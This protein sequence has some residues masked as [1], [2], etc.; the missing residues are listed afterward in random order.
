MREYCKVLALIE[1]ESL[2]ASSFHLTNHAKQE[3]KNK[4]DKETQRRKGRRRESP[5]FF[6]DL[7]FEA[8]FVVEELVGRFLL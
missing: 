1:F 3:R 4:K 6:F 5:E 8:R 2:V 7:S